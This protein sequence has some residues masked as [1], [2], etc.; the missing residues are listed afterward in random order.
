LP[1]RAPRRTGL[2]AAAADLARDLEAQG[3]RHVGPPGR[4]D[5]DVAAADRDIVGVHH[6]AGL[7]DEQ[8][9]PAA[10]VRVDLQQRLGDDRLGE[11][12]LDITARDPHL[13]PARHHPAAVT[14]GA[15]TAALKAD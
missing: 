3:Y 11:V 9:P 10:H 15:A 7:G 12:E 8:Q 14:L 5:L 2:D 13:D 4:P 6:D 1:E